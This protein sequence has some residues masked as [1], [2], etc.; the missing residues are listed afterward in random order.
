[1]QKNNKYSIRKLKTG[2]ASVAVA[3][4]LMGFSPQ[5]VSAEEVVG[6]SI[7]VEEVV[8]ESEEAVVETLEESVEELE[9]TITTEEQVTHE[10]VAFETEYIENADWLRGKEV[11][12]Q[13]GITGERTIIEEVT[14]SDGEE[15]SREIIS[16][17]ITTK[18]QPK[19][20]ERGTL[21]YVVLSETAKNYSAV[22][23]QPWSINTLPWGVYG[24]ELA[25]NGVDYVGEQVTVSK[26]QATERGTF[27]LIS[28]N[29]KDLG[30]IDKGALEVHAVQ[31]TKNVQYVAKVTRAWSI[32]SQP[33]GTD[34]YVTVGNGSDYMG[35]SVNVIQEKV[36]N[37]STYLLLELNGKQI[38]WIDYTG[39][40]KQSDIQSVKDVQYVANVTKNW[41]INTEP[42]GTT[43]SKF[44]MNAASYVGKSVDVTQEKQTSRSTYALINFGGKELGWID[45]T[46]IDEL[47]VKSTKNT[48]YIATVVEPWSINTKP[49]GVN[50][51][52]TVATGSDYMGKNVQVTQEQTTQRG[53]YALISVD[54]V[55]VGWI[56]KGALTQFHTVL[57]TTDK[58]YVAKVTK[59]WSINSE[60][61]GT[62]GAKQVANGSAYV[63]KNVEVLQ[64]KVTN[65]SIYALISVNGKQVGWID[66]TGLQE[67]VVQS[68]KDITYMA[69]V[70]QPWSINTQPW[71][72]N[73]YELVTSGSTYLGQYIEVVQEKVTSRGTYSLIR[74]E[75]TDIGWIDKGALKVFHTVVS[76]KDVNYV[77][78]VTKPWSINSAPWGTF[79]AKLVA[80]GSKYIDKDVT[81][82]QEKVTER[83]TYA[84]INVAGKDIGWID[85]TGLDPLRALYQRDIHY[86]ATVTQPWSINTAPWGTEGS[87][88]VVSARDYLGKD[89]EVTKEM[90]TQR[91]TYAR[92]QSGSKVLG[93]IDITGLKPYTV[94][95]TKNVT[96]TATI[97]K[98]WSINTQPWGTLQYRPVTNY[99]SYH[100]KKAQVIQEKTTRRGTYALLQIDGKII[101][102]I[103][104]GA[105][106]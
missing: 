32:N 93:W 34:G 15:I 50:G 14:F 33:W 104:K 68:T 72:V 25:A 79:E 94:L 27:A 98:P 31:S 80:D 20:I 46:G 64:E 23:R 53:T 90:R 10:P 59:P 7:P 29:G 38:G 70:I 60:P 17:E 95:T 69:T 24:F 92:V 99:S 105:L 77:A 89:L 76:T 43:G 56:D 73:G 57:E 96:Y 16:N 88:F 3:A 61:W 35:Q 66:K 40:T 55:T 58:N 47:V 42:W 91:G 51:Y 37:R 71:G 54:G 103:D 6:E 100:G 74:V 44:V 1:M 18:S 102:W 28:Y 2:V 83:S 13:E 49:W 82:V 97:V 67:I 75:G 9:A 63:G 52:Q 21:E 85:M 106:R 48:D 36:T 12:V 41:S 65:R 87:T 39:V 26:E 81:V 78:K 84:L 4:I 5:A 11:V 19:R 22:V 8:P 30:W 45:K 86:M 62:Y 101:G